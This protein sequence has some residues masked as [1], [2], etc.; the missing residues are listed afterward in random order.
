MKKR[1]DHEKGVGRVLKKRREGL[2][3]ECRQEA[4]HA[5]A[6]ASKRNKQGEQATTSETKRKRS[7]RNEEDTEKH[8]E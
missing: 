4:K 8:E 3:N 7:T 1:S 5:Q 2:S 6:Q